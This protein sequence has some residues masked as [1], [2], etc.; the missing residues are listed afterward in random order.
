MEPP[1]NGITQKFRKSVGSLQAYQ[2][3]N[4]FIAKYTNKPR[5][6]YLNSIFPDAKF[7]HILR[8]GNATVNSLYNRVKKAG[9]IAPSERKQ[10]IKVFPKDW[11]EGIH[12]STEPDIT[13]LAYYY[14]HI[15]TRI[16]E[17]QKWLNESRTITVRYKGFTTSPMEAFRSVCDFLEVPWTKR[18]KTHIRSNRLESRNYK[19]EKNLSSQQIEEMEDILDGFPVPTLGSEDDL[20]I[21]EGAEK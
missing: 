2:G 20:F 21:I 14:R 11:Q 19:W 7:V 5:I 17:Q 12:R 10:W 1:S 16:F 6:K 8:D 4:R 15:V 13:F 18:F 3:K 9:W